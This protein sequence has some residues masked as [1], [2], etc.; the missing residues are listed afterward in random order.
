MWD[1]RSAPF[2][3]DYYGLGL[4]RVVIGV[5]PANEMNGV[6]VFRY[7][8]QILTKDPNLEH[9]SCRVDACVL[10]IV[11]RLENDV[12][13]NGD[14]WGDQPEIL[15]LNSQ[16][17]MKSERLPVLKLS[18]TSKTEREEQVRIIGYNQGGEGLIGP[19]E[20]LNRVL[21]FAI[22]YYVS[23]YPWVDDGRSDRTERFKPNEEMIVMC[24][25][26]G[27][28]SGGPCVN[29]QG[30]VIGIL[31]RADSAESQRCYLV[32]ASELKSL[33]SSAKKLL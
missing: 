21:D 30:E 2:G 25:T 33:V 26:I 8:A 23:T 20:S 5:I 17:T 9:G 16:R 28:H 18:R 15:L 32:P 29:L 10:Q 13:G 19:G 1:D 6:A 11:T 27:G 31:S 14:N 24:P 3:E 7:F 12:L 4:G 22:G